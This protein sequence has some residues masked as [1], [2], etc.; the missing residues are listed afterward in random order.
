MPS[1][2]LSLHPCL[3]FCRIST[4]HNLI[5]MSQQR[6]PRYQGCQILDLCDDDFTLGSLLCWLKNSLSVDGTKI[7]NQHKKFLIT[8]RKKCSQ[9]VTGEALSIPKLSP[10]EQ[11]LKLSYKS[12][13]KRLLS[14]IAQNNIP[15][16]NIMA[17]LKTY[18][19]NHKIPENIIITHQ[20]YDAT[21]ITVCNLNTLK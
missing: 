11:T 13:I 17:R 3:D 2:F 15:G 4:A 21:S 9:A 19:R 12:L 8:V 14:G 20:F 6:S 16:Y 18:F 10:K 5:H 1:F 7:I